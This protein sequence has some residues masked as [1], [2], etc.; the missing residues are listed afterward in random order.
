MNLQ[1]QP[2]VS[3]VQSTA[4]FHSFHSWVFII[5]WK[6]GHRLFIR[7]FSQVMVGG[8]NLFI[9]AIHYLLKSL[10]RRNILNDVTATPFSVFFYSCQ[11]RKRHHLWLSLRTFIRSNNFI[12][13]QRISKK[14][15][16]KQTNHAS[17]H[18]PTTITYTTSYIESEENST[19]DTYPAITRQGVA[20]TT[21]FV[22]EFY[23]CASGV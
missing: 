5:I 21:K 20:V 15:K 4:V 12:I 9:A 2:Y 6:L 22:C 8:S 16:L 19:T 14:K 11:L 7:I 23:L 3:V 1:Q 13:I 17:A 10:L 18:H